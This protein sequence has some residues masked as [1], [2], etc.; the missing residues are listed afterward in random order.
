MTAL[1]LSLF[2]LSLAGGQLL[3][4]PVPG[5]EVNVYLCDI[6]AFLTVG[7]WLVIKIKKGQPVRFLGREKLLF[8]FA[9]WA[10]LSLLFSL[11]WVSRT[12]LA[13][14]FLY[15]LRFL[16]YSFLLWVARDLARNNL[17]S[18]ERIY[19]LF[20]LSGIAVLIFGF[21]QVIFFPD[22]TYLAHA[23]G[24]DPHR[25]RLASTF[26]DPNFAGAY[27]ALCYLILGYKVISKKDL[28]TGDYLLI[29]LFILGIVLTFSRSTWLLFGVAML[30]I[31]LMRF[32]I[33]AAVS[34]GLLL[35][36]I[37]IIPRAQTRVYG[38]IVPDESA[39]LRFN[40]WDR[41]VTL[42]RAFPL[43]G[44]GFNTLREAQA[45][46]GL[47]SAEEVE[48]RSAA[49]I[50]SS[51]LF[52]LA[53]TGILGLTFYLMFYGKMLREVYGLRKKSL[54]GLIYLAGAV[55]LLAGSFFIN[56]LFYSP[57]LAW[58]LILPATITDGK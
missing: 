25:F 29:P 7:S 5:R 17:I 32:R 19:H 22:F 34:L 48:S 51:L 16:I 38:G 57:L 1:L 6:L 12:G 27:L 33:F 4:I 56:N 13:V 11:A 46:Q 24:W 40:S 52:V 31:G 10:F 9:I 35:S 45:K 36:A 14:G 55:G 49:G 21:F 26:L 41:A 54:E 2:I 50:D 53:T 3:R 28:G 42:F 30:V 8:C 43:A 15:W 20:L 37:L 23:Y 58:L 18:K 39:R 44:T 47:L